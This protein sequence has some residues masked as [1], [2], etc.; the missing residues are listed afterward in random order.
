MKLRHKLI[1]AIAIL[2]ITALVPVR[3][4]TVTVA[5]WNIRYNNPGDGVNAWPNRKDRVLEQ[6]RKADPEIL[7]LQEVLK[8]QLD[9]LAKAL[10]G[11]A[12]TGA[13][14]DDG[15]EAGEYVPVFYLDKL[16]DQLESGHFWLSENPEV[17]GKLGWDAACPRMVTWLS[18]NNTK[19]GDTLFIFNTHLD[20]VGVVARE[21]GSQMLAEKARSLADGHPMIITGDFNST[22]TDIAY[23]TMFFNL[24]SDSRSKSVNPP[25]GPEY[26]FTGFDATN[27]PGG[28]IDYIFIQNIS[29]VVNYKTVPKTVNGYYNSDHL[30]V[31]TVLRM[32]GDE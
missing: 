16:F 24:F 15:K 28:R 27:P 11:Y 22:P 6:I 5:T 9:D 21:K 10:P 32:K 3:S 26:T 14:R 2:I 12:W 20:H 7:C 23:E 13:G 18:L 19:T 31:V 17:P 1:P 29:E 25:E 8:N 4:Q 30:M